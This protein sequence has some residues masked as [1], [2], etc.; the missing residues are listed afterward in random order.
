MTI[1]WILSQMLLYMP[2]SLW[3]FSQFLRE[4]KNNSL[5]L[6][7]YL[8]VGTISINVGSLNV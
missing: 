1:F 3:G 6:T 4:A 8:Q 5:I 7:E 2:V